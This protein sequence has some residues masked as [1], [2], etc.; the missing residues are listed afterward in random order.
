MDVMDNILTILDDHSDDSDDDYEDE[1][2]SEASND[3]EDDKLSNVSESTKN[4]WA[5][6][7]EFTAEIYPRGYRFPEYLS[8]QELY[9]SLIHI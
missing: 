3:N 1:G 9:L 5:V 7:Q 2:E 4:P 8:Y 6:S